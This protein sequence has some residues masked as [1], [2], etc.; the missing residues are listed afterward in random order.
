MQKAGDISVTNGTIYKN[1]T[2]LKNPCTMKNYTNFT[3]A[4]AK[5]NTEIRILNLEEMSKIRGGGKS[6]PPDPDGFE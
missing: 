3:S 2:L 1:R 6:E 4:S 5:M